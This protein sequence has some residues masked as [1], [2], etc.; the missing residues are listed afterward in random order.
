MT[1]RVATPGASDPAR[2]LAPV[3]GEAPDGP[4]VV[5]E[6][7]GAPVAAVGL[8]DG[9]V[10]ADPLLCSPSIVAALRLRRWEVWLI[11]ALWGC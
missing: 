1:F 10:A 3:A 11:G 5:A 7:S 9:R 4:L 2:R 6:I 8:G